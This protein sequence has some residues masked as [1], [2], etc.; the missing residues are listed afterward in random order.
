MYEYYKEMT[1]FEVTRIVSARAL[2]IAMGAPI[3][4]RTKSKVPEQIAQ[5][6][7]ERGVL[8]ITVIRKPPKKI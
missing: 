6:E 3:L 2:Q 8:P 1:R 7:F 5:E 4:I